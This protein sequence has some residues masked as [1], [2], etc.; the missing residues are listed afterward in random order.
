MSVARYQRRSAGGGGLQQG[1]QSRRLDV[2]HRAQPAERRD[3]LVEL[4]PGAKPI[5][6]LAVEGHRQGEGVLA[7]HAV[8]RMQHP[9][10]PVAIVGEQE[11]ALGVLVQA[12]DR[13]EACP[14]GDERRRDEVEHRPLG[15]AIARGRRDAGRLVEHEIR[16]RRRPADDP[17][18]HGDDGLLRVH[19]RPEG[20][21]L[22]IHRDATGDDHR[23]GSPPG[24]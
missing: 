8:A 1:R 17:A 11:H 7:L 18:V 4:D 14:V 2:G 21:G 16:L 20:R 24:S 23:F 3:P 10:G 15:M 19:P 9:L 5:H 13:V 22:A 6:L 12:S